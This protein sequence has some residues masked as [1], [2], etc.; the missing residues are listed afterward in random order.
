MTIGEAARRIRG[1]RASRAVWETGA[2]WLQGK[3]AG[4]MRGRLYRL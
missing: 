1:Q 4:D 2:R 3:E